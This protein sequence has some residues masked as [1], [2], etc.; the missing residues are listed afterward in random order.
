M[1]MSG[2]RITVGT[3]VDATIIYALI[4]NEREE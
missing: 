4:E 1:S 3:I 2:V